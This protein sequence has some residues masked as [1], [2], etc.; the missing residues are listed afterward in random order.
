MKQLPGFAICAFLWI[1]QA[2]TGFAQEMRIEL[3]S[4]RFEQPPPLVVA[5]PGI[6][7]VPDQSD[8]IFYM[9]GWYWTRRGG[10]W[11]R[12]H[13][14]RGQW[15]VAERRVV[16]ERLYDVPEGRYRHW[17]AEQRHEERR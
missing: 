10:H 3:P 15:V 9:D 17:H 4:I 13:D 12:T 7:V 6:Q 1:S 5:E 16:P 14:Y 11:F 8:E 2:A